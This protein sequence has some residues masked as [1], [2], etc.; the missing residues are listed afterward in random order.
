MQYDNGLEYK[1]HKYGE[2]SELK[3]DNSNRYSPIKRK[4]W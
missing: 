4:G 2:L 1:I 3:E